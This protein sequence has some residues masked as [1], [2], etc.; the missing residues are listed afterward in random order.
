MQIDPTLSVYNLVTRTKVQNTL[1]NH[2]RTM[3][4]ISY[5]IENATLIDGAKTR[6][7]SGFQRLSKFLPQVKRYEE[8]ARRAESVHIFGI[9]DAAPPPLQNVVYVGLPPNAQLAKEWF[10]ISYGR[11][12]MSVLATEEQTHIDD[13]DHLRVF[14][15]VW[16]FDHEMASILSDWLSSA[17]GMRT[18]E[19]EESQRNYPRMMELM[20]KSMSRMISRVAYER[21]AQIKRELDTATAAVTPPAAS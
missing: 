9:A 7:F 12:Y 8:I 15:G 5:E 17:L 2:R 20:G 21:E 10:I 1:V 11:D 18:L 3:S 4:A 16:S 6:I 13:P 14:K 19:I